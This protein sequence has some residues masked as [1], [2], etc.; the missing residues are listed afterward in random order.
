MRV[1]ESV[2]EEDIT[3]SR[4]QITKVKDQKLSELRPPRHEEHSSN[5][6]T[7]SVKHKPSPV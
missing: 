4:D 7:A 6:T 1:I 5:S 3:R 2:V